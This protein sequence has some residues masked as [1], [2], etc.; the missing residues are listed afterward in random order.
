MYSRIFSPARRARVMS[1]EGARIF[2]ATHMVDIFELT[3]T[4]AGVVTG[5][6]AKP[7]KNGENEKAA[8]EFCFERVS[9]SSKALP[10]RICGTAAGAGGPARM[11]MGRSAGAR[12]GLVFLRVVISLLE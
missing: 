5:W 7:P 2:G 11:G 6:S 9:L 3:S 8:Q 12:G 1:I 10:H 4:T